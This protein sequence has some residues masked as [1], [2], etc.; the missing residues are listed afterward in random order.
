MK[1]KHF[2][3]VKELKK[4]VEKAA[5]EVRERGAQGA[6]GVRDSGAVYYTTGQTA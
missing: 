4:E 2:T 1:I 6:D 5:T 3:T